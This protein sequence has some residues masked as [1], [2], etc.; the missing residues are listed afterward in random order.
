MFELAEEINY[1]P[2]NMKSLEFPSNTPPEK[3]AT[4]PDNWNALLSMDTEILKGQREEIERRW[5][6]WITQ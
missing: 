1:D 4:Y 3:R 5:Q 6:E 2:P